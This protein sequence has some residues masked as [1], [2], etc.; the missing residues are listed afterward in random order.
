MGGIAGVQS[1]DEFL[2]VVVGMP[3]DWNMLF[4]FFIFPD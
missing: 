3:S 1:Y 4:D 2:F